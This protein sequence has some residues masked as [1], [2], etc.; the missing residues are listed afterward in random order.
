MQTFKDLLEQIQDQ[1]VP[2][3]KAAEMFMR[4]RSAATAAHVAHL[5]TPSY[6][7]HTALNDFYEG[8][9]PLIDKF[10]ETFIGRYGKL[11]NF[12]NVK[13]PSTDGLTILGNYTMWIDKNRELISDLSEIQNIIDEI[14]GFCSSI[15]YKLR[16]LK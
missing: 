9:I 15:A 1:N 14:S 7:S 10:A 5:M 8:I 11:E 2:K 12:P 16:E 4:G 13:E 6:A 3:A